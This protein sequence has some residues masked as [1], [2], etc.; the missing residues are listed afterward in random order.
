[1]NLEDLHCLEKRTISGLCHAILESLGSDFLEYYDLN[2]NF[3]IPIEHTLVTVERVSMS[4]TCDFARI[5]L[6]KH[7]MNSV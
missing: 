2:T 3:F 4:E 5:H 1:M 6:Y 7:L